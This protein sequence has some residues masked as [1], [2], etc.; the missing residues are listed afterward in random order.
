M[1]G[2]AMPG[3][4]SAPPRAW[5]VRRRARVSVLSAIGGLLLGTPLAGQGEQGSGI[6]PV[7]EALRGSWEGS[8]VLMNRPAEFT[9]RWDVFDDGF[10]RLAF[11]NSF[12]NEGGGSTPLMSA[13]ATY[14]VEEGGAIGVWLDDR[15]QR[16][17]LEAVLTDSSFVVTWTADAERGRTEYVVR[18]A[19]TAAVR[20]FVHGDGQ[21]RLFGEATYR[22]R[23]P[24][25]E[26][27]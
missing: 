18:S 13:Q 1:I 3:S 9:M 27:P 10:A 5:T 26:R 22:R 21:E 14:L 17:T 20:D 6:A 8:G 24:G 23:E 15:P 19:D 25:P 12:V 4:A 11:T 2:S 7:L 16:L